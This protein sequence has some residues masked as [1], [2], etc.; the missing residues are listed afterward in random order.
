MKPLLVIAA[1]VLPLT[2]AQACRFTRPPP[3]VIP[4]SYDPDADA[5]LLAT[6]LRVRGMSVGADVRIDEIV[7]GR[8]P[9]RRLHIDTFAALIPCTSVYGLRRGERLLVVLGPGPRGTSVVNWVPLDVARQR[10][11]F[12]AA[13]LAAG[14]RAARR[15]VV[16]HWRAQHSPEGDADR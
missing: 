2:P 3:P 10:E 1:F 16:E 8:T 14:R 7:D 12:I 11:P 5:I 6:A 4:A 15:R 9:I 13:Y